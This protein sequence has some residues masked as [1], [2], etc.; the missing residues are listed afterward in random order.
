MENNESSTPKPAVAGTPSTSQGV[1]GPSPANPTGT[2]SLREDLLARNI[3]MFGQ[4][5][6]MPAEASRFP[7][8]FQQ[9]LEKFKIRC[10]NQIVGVK[11]DSE[12]NLCVLVCHLDD[13]EQ[14][15]LTLKANPWFRQTVL[16]TWCSTVFVWFRVTGWRPHNCKLPGM[17]WISD[18]ILPA[19][20]IGGPELYPDGFPH[21]DFGTAL[22]QI[23]F[24]DLK[25][26]PGLHEEFM[27]LRH[28]DESGRLLEVIDQRPVLNPTT[29]ARFLIARL[30][31]R[32][33]FQTDGFT[34]TDAGGK[35]MSLT[36]RNLAL[37]IQ[38]WLNQKSDQ[39]GLPPLPETM[40]E[41]VLAKIIKAVAIGPEEGLELFVSR[42]LSRRA[43]SSVTMAELLTEYERF[44]EARG[45]AQLPARKFY[46]AVT[47]SLRNRFG[48]AKSRDI[49]RQGAEGRVTDKAGFRN[50]SLKSD[51]SDASD[52]SDASCGF[53]K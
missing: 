10:P 17:L 6:V 30:G 46:Q 52:A 8:F 19:V 37:T 34:M 1:G 42:C 35:T 12:S 22:R 27:L 9:M 4:G 23:E 29:A 51:W 45:V 2:A 25:W 36:K 32:Y 28:E 44:S 14:L 48:S 50:L 5:E 21:K 39:A 47:V 18:G 26:N 40:V 16:T 15:N 49:R 20:K 43:G 31:L 3:A 7:G 38:D 41:E 33:R 11:C 53:A 24:A 13:Q